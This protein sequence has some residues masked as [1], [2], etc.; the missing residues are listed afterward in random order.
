[1]ASANQTPITSLITLSGMTCSGKS[2]LA[3]KL[4]STGF[5]ERVVTATTRS[6]RQ[7]K[8]R[9]ES[10]GVDYLFLSEIDFQRLEE[11]QG[12]LESTQ[13]SNHRYGT[14]LSS[15]QA[16]QKSGLIPLV[17]IDPE[18]AQSLKQWGRREGWDVLNVFLACDIRIAL[19]RLQNRQQR[20]AIEN[21]P[22]DDERMNAL[23]CKESAWASQYPWDLTL[24]QFTDENFSW[25][26]S[27]L[28]SSCKD[29]STVAGDHPLPTNDIGIEFP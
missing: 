26:L 19:E 23:M 18:G 25:Q 28:L 20:A 22:A 6:P 7:L 21:S 8:D 1:M 14:P 29:G 13:F 10:H 3:T 11:A 2:S 12:L 17:I 24:H 5:F 15:L 16:V 9:V 27:L 4:L